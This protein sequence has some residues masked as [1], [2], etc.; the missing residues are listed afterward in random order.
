MDDVKLVPARMLLDKELIGAINFHCGDGNVCGEY[1]DGLLWV[2]TATDD[3]GAEVYGLHLQTAEH[4]EEGSTTLVEFA[5]PLAAQRLRADTAEAQTKLA[6]RELEIAAE[7]L[8]AAEQRIADLSKALKDLV[9]INEQ[10]NRAISQIAGTP[11]GWKDKYLDAAR[12][13]LST[14]SPATINQQG[15]GA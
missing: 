5:E 11:T 1:C 9:W 10:H 2:G 15:E 7:Q 3:E 8:V 6:N 13:A 14:A 4:P 12:A